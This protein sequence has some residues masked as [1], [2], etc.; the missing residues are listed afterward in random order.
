VGARPRPQHLA[1]D[2]FWHLGHDTMVTSE[3]GTPDMVTSGLN[4]ELLLAGKY[5]HQLH[6]WD[7]RTRTTNRPSTWGPSTKWCSS[8]AR[9]RPHQ[10]LRLRRRRDLDRGSLRFGVGVVPGRHRRNERWA[11]RKVI[12]IPAEPRTPSRCRRC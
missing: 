11:A 9:A 8:F 12:T 5:G 4:P 2:F 1:Y 7:L 6:V 10:G 3:W